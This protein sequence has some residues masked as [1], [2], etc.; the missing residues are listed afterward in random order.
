MTHPFCRIELLG[1]LRMRHGD[2]PFVHLPVRKMGALLGYL[3][4]FPGRAHNREELA[5]MLWPEET[6]DA[7]RSRFRQLLSTLRRRLEPD[8]DHGLL[9]ADRTE[10]GLDARAVT[11]DV[12]DF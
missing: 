12:L 4:L 2:E 1:G 3:A 9:I 11:T 5:E 7:T 6:L 8:P 10:V